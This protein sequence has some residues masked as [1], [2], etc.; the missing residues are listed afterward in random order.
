[1]IGL[2]AKREIVTRA[3]QGV[4]LAMIC[5]LLAGCA[6]R[7]E[8]GMER[9][10]AS[11]ADLEATVVAMAAENARLATQVASL[12]SAT[13]VP[14]TPTSIVNAPEV[15]TQVASATAGTPTTG[16]SDAATPTPSSAV[17]ATATPQP[18]ATS[19]PPAPRVE[20]A[21]AS[22]NL[23]SGP[24]TAYPVEG[25]ATQGQVFDVLRRSRAADWLEISWSGGTRWIAAG[26]V[27]ANLPVE[28]L[29]VATDVAPPP[30]SLPPSPTPVPTA[31]TAPRCDSVPIRG[32]GT[33][34]GE[35]PEVAAVLGCPSGYPTSGEVGTETAVQTFER[36]VMF[37]L[38]EDS[39][40]ARDPVYVLFDNGDYQRFPDMGPA[41]PAVV[42]AIDAGFFAPGPHFSKAYWE[43][44]GA[45]VRERLGRATEQQTESPGAYQQFINGRMF[46]SKALKRI[47][48]LYDYWNYPSG[49]PA[50]QVRNW[51]SFEDAF[52]AQ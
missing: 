26:L 12:S 10:P 41:D 27:K 31:G 46:W 47:F 38:A 24:G 3:A 43:G 35:H 17:T 21:V 25:Q 8:V 28:S 19:E 40:N 44:T 50:R 49:Q 39:R 15:T 9:T 20:V 45:R 13:A 22:A 37:W 23:R 16:V 4:A 51:A 48:V 42:G 30:T 29:P 34:W 11:R 1:M 18:S 6:G 32:F 5:V 14:S 36:G 2:Q 33:V 52:G 7:F